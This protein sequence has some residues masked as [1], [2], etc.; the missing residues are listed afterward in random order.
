VVTVTGV[1]SFT[2]L[3]ASSNFFAQINLTPDNSY[4]PHINADTYGSSPIVAS[5]SNTLT[6]GTT[7]YFVGV[8]A[9][10]AFPLTYSVTLSGPGGILTNGA[11]AGVPSLAP[12]NRINWHFGDLSAVI[13]DHEDGVVVY[14]WAD[15]ASWLGLH[16]TQELVANAD[17]NQA[18]DIPIVEYNERG[19]QFAFY[20]LDSGEY[21]INIWTSDNKLYEIIA[22]NLDFANATMRGSELGS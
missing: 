5:P 20:I 14:C 11:S 4:T 18:Q 1:Y 21:L 6:A 8:S 19:C 2:G 22:D 7:Y 16:I 3:S 12:D 10:S 13:Y 9:C 17:T 15:G